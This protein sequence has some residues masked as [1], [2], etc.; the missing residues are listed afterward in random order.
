MQTDSKAFC[1]L[2]LKK[3]FTF[4]FHKLQLIFSPVVLTVSISVDTCF[5]YFPLQGSVCGID[6][7][8]SIPTNIPRLLF[9]ALPLKSLRV[10]SQN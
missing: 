3:S 4:P 9:K 1:A 6:K 2:S 5:A 10:I 7:L 8:V